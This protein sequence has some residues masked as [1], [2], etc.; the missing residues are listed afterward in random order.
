MPEPLLSTSS[1]KNAIKA[2][3][4]RLGFLLAGVTTPDTPQS[5]PAFERWLGLGMQAGMG[6]LSSERSLLARRDPAVLLPEVKSILVLAYPYA[7]PASVPGSPFDPTGRVAAYAWGR[8]YHLVLPPLF[9]SIAGYISAAAGRD[10]TW[11]AFTDSAPI[12]ERDLAVRAG[13]GWI[14]R[15]TCLIHPLRGSYFFLAEL[16][17]DLELE[18]DKPFTMDYC[19]ACRRCIDACPT[20]AIL[21]DRTLDSGRCISYLTIENLAGIP[22]DFVGS[23]EG[24][25]FGCDLC[26][27]VCPWNIRFAG[28]PAGEVLESVPAEA[29]VLLEQVLGL[30]EAAF[31]REFAGRPHLRPKRRGWLRNALALI[32]NYP[33]RASAH[34]LVRFIK[35]EADPALRLQAVLALESM[36]VHLDRAD[37]Q[38]LA[39]KEMDPVVAASLDA[40]LASLLR[41]SKR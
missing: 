1:V 40:I 9:E 10:L 27:M 17:L 3:A 34:Q 38:D 24:W 18:P 37:I 8:D 6:Y 4:E 16:F 7:D 23:L 20:H 5:F 25:I 29:Y 39:E 32:S 14:G 2:E 35:A 26:Q 41:S 28:A 12:L 13:L 33:S 30:D 21:E 36:E 31:R 22:A 19:G 15:N 11:K